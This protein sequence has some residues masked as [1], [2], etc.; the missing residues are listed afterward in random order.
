MKEGENLH[1]LV[2]E[3]IRWLRKVNEV[4]VRDVYKSIGVEYVPALVG[5]DD[6][7]ADLTLA[8]QSRIRTCKT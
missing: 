8:Y 4:T 5:W 1:D 3:H 2:D 6:L 7:H